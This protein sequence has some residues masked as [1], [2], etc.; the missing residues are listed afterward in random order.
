[1]PTR[2]IAREGDA[3]YAEIFKHFSGI[4]EHL[5]AAV[6]KIVEEQRESTP[7]I[8]FGDIYAEAISE[9]ISA[10]TGTGEPVVWLASVRGGDSTKVSL[11]LREETA[12]EL[13]RFSRQVHR[14]QSAVVGTALDRYL[15]KRS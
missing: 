2:R 11:W 13:E 15:K 6:R 3:A 1:M 14:S 4:P 12:E 8:K 9:I 7:G 5:V 10:H